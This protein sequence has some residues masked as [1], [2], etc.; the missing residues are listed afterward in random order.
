M[1]AFEISHALLVEKQLR[2]AVDSAAL[3]GALALNGEVDPEGHQHEPQAKESAL[4]IFRKCSISGSSLSSAQSGST[5][6]DPGPGA[7][8]FELKAEHGQP[9]APGQTSAP[10]PRTVRVTAVYGMKPLFA[11]F[12][13]IRDV[14]I[15]VSSKAGI[16]ATK[17]DIV[18]VV[19]CSFGMGQVAAGGGA[20]GIDLAR[21]TIH[22]LVD[23]VAK[24]GDTRF[25]LVSYSFGV[26]GGPGGDSPL[27]PDHPLRRYLEPTSLKMND[28]G[29]DAH[30][31]HSVISALDY[32]HTPTVNAAY[33]GANTAA[34]LEKAYAMLNGDKHR[35][36]AEKIIILFTGGLP[37]A[38]Y[39]FDQEIN[40]WVL[41]A[42]EQLPYPEFHD[43][44]SSSDPPRRFLKVQNNSK[45][46]VTGELP[47]TAMAHCVNENTHTCYKNGIT[48][49][50][51]GFLRGNSGGDHQNGNAMNFL[52][53]MKFG[54]WG[55][56]ESYFAESPRD[57]LHIKMEFF[58]DMV[59]LL[60]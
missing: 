13:G 27:R 28:L 39:Y 34:G 36:D 52:K 11:Q 6:S 59:A 23:K 32:D 57:L 25:G 2:A 7:C 16:P 60:D 53:N 43:P 14:P 20:T 45:Q 1:F 4:G 21:N 35:V 37:T 51:I 54:A 58:N 41:I 46:E 15:S 31:I 19:D 42:A 56:S 17:R 22:D 38:R 50:S 44:A 18:L 8:R 10:P 33:G 47:W 26:P 24:S 55:R 48:M 49:Y 9:A 12:L 30:A 29:A 3:A 5:Q 40:D